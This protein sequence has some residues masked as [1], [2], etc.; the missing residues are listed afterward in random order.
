[1]LNSFFSLLKCAENS[2][3]LLQCDLCIFCRLRKARA[4]DNKE[5]EADV[6]EALQQKCSALVPPDTSGQSVDS[7]PVTAEPQQAAATSSLPSTQIINSLSTSSEKMEV[8]NNDEKTGVDAKTL[9]SN[10]ASAAEPSSVSS[11]GASDP[12]PGLASE[13]ISPGLAAA[14][15]VAVCSSPQVPL[16]GMPLAS[17]SGAQQSSVTD[18][19]SLPSSGDKEQSVSTAPTERSKADVEPKAPDVKPVGDSTDVKENEKQV[20]IDPKVAD[21][22][23]SDTN[24]TA[25]VSSQRPA[26]PGKQPEQLKVTPN[27]VSKP[28]E[29]STE[30]PASTLTPVSQSVTQGTPQ[31]APS[32]GTCTPSASSNTTSQVVTKPPTE[33]SEKASQ[34]VSKS[35]LPGASPAVLHEPPK[36][37]S[38]GTSPSAPTIAKQTPLVTS[39]SSVHPPQSTTASSSAGQPV[40]TSGITKPSITSETHRAAPIKTFQHLPAGMIAASS[41]QFRAITT[42]PSKETNKDTKTDPVKPQEPSTSTKL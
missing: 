21:T 15:L 13:S 24:N 7:E 4:I 10:S 36:G 16:Q 25:T 5:S 35:T 37:T 31:A 28:K 11:S 30:V 3:C 29:D 27:V 39:A 42:I 40:K 38:R 20:S 18:S 34:D 12:S 26:S 14:S 2:A 23:S 41:K 32:R 6:S 17:V 1:M 8:E 9:P 19:K 33:P 22:S